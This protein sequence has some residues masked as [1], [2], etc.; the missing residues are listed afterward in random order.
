MNQIT[1]CRS[2]RSKNIVDIA[3]FGEQYLSEFRSDDKKPDK[4]PLELVLCNNCTLVQL[5]NSTPP[6][7]LYTD[8]YGYRSGINNTIKADLKDIV[9]R[10]TK[11]VTLFPGDVVVD[12]GANDGTLL[13]NYDKSYLR[14]GYEP[15]K[16]LARAAEEHADYIINDFFNA[17]AFN[18]AFPGKKAKIIT[19]INCFY[20]LEDPNSVVEDLASI[21]DEDGVLVIE[22]NYLAKMLT[23]NAFDNI[24]HEHIEYYT[25]T[26]LEHLLN[27]H[28]LEVVGIRETSI[29]GGAFRVYVKHMNPLQKYRAIEKNMRLDNKWTYFL[30]SLRVK[31]IKDKVKKFIEEKKAEGETIYLYGASTRGNS[32]IQVCGLDNKLITAAVERNSEKWGTRIASLGIPIIS[33]EQARKEKPDYMLVLPWFFGPEFIEREKEYLNSGGTFL[34]PLPQPYLIDR[35]GKHEL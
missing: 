12:I 19:F 29:N 27:R 3:D 9:E 28:F 2:C 26:S 11:T 7:K 24:V 32:L 16:K 25:L 30:F 33:E 15:I 1:A 13:S 21:L 35:D 8:N 31:S 22:Q 5:K 4:Y 20:D 10:A 6:E 34:F 23:Q 14:I 18:K 17:E